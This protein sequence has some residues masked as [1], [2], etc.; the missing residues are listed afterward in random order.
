[1][2]GVELQRALEELDGE[3]GTAHAAQF[4]GLREL[5]RQELHVLGSALGPWIGHGMAGG[6]GPEGEGHAGLVG[7]ADGPEGLAKEEVG[8]ARGGFSG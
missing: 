8:G 7:S 1:M 5:V 2:V 4:V 3:V 6:G